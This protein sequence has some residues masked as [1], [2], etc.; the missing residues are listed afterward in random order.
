[1]TNPLITARNR[2][3]ECF[4]RTSRK[5]RHQATLVQGL[6]DRLVF[7]DYPFAEHVATICASHGWGVRESDDPRQPDHAVKHLRTNR[8]IY[9]AQVNLQ[10][11]ACCLR[12][13]DIMDFDRSRTPLAVFE[14]IEFTED[15]SWE[16][17]NK[18]LAVCGW[19]IKEREVMYDMQCAH[20]AFYV[21][22]HEFV[23]WIDAELRDCRYLIED[24][25]AETGERYKLHLP[26]VVDRR[27]VEMKDK[28]YLAGAFHFQLEYKEIMRLLMDKSLY[29][30]PSLFLRELLQNSLDACRH[31]QA[32][33][34]EAGRSKDY[35]PRIVVWDQSD[36]ADDP[37]I[38][39][40]DNGIGMSQRIVEQYFMRIGRSYYRSPEFDVERDRLA[41][42]NVELDA[43]SCFGIGIL[44]C[45]LV[46]DRF[47]VETYRHGHEPM[48]LTIEGPNKYFVIKRLAKS[49]TAQF[50]PRPDSDEDD[51]PPKRP[52]TRV[53]VHLRP[54]AK[55]DAY[56]VLDLFAVNADYDLRVHRP[57]RKRPK[58]IHKRRWEQPVRLRDFP[59]AIGDKDKWLSREEGRRDMRGDVAENLEGAV[60]AERI[61]MEKWDFSRHLRGRAWFWLLQAADGGACMQ[62]GYLRVAN[63]LCL[64]GLGEVLAQL[65]SRWTFT[66]SQ[67][68]REKLVEYLTDHLQPPADPP[69]RGRRALPCAIAPGVV[70]PDMKYLRLNLGQNFATAWN[71]LSVDERR[72]TCDFVGG[73]DRVDAKPWL[74]SRAV[75]RKLRDGVFDWKG[76]SVE[77]GDGGLGKDSALI[78]EGRPNHFALRAV[79]LPAG[80]VSWDPSRGKGSPLGLLS[81]PGELQLDVRG[82]T[83]PDPPASRLFVHADQ[84]AEIV[85]PY[86][87]AALRHG[88][89]LVAS[90]QH[91]ESAIDWFTLLCRAPHALAYPYWC[92]ALARELTYIEDR[93]PYSSSVGHGEEYVSRAELVNQFGRWVPLCGGPLHPPGVKYRVPL[94]DIL[95][96]FH[97][98]RAV[99]G[100][101]PEVDMETVVEPPASASHAT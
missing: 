98:R 78:Q 62:R 28:R 21:A 87:R 54:N 58:V 88:A 30:D 70:Q 50:Q 94:N 71:D 51:G 33:A 48:H 79:L 75:V 29:P 42:K 83:A 47:E 26:H 55:V 68:F 22:V 89:D 49:D 36:D 34:K 46:A 12:L 44:S 93:V 8:P 100:R 11:L 77:F 43:C 2:H 40:Q 57:K 59:E 37:R 53:T 85:V 90:A 92:K 14:H 66:T 52:G 65:C 84:A 15:K 24:A 45:F 64:A 19:S 32:L 23:D 97:P 10:Y 86:L 3:F 69:V 31:Q 67:D 35:K 41:S 80:I 5:I 74:L 38:V 72:A 1:M 7:R 91:V 25:P 99:K 56:E 17:W 81:V 6:A 16:E 18:H 60:V 61:P 63:R 101:V 27:K 9:G 20:P 4:L 73:Y 13:A 96:A 82:S 76:Q 39:F 95:L